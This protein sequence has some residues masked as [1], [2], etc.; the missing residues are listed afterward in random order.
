MGYSLGL[1]ES[2]GSILD[3]KNCIIILFNCSSIF[4]AKVKFLS[5]NCFK[6]SGYAGGSNGHSSSSELGNITSELFVKP[7]FQVLVLA[8]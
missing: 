7:L 6:W 3:F 5:A 4:S 8:Y 2:L 1:F